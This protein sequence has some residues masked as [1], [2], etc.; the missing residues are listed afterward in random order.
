MDIADIKEAWCNPRMDDDCSING[1]PVPKADLGKYLPVVDPAEVESQD[2]TCEYPI[3]YDKDY[4]PVGI[5]S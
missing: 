4:K 5:R 2:G 1:K 3:C